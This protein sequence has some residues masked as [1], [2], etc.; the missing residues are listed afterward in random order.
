MLSLIDTKPMFPGWGLVYQSGV[1]ASESYKGNGLTVSMSGNE[2]WRD[3]C[4]W[5]NMRDDDV[6]VLTTPMLFAMTSAALGFLRRGFNVLIHCNEGKYRSTYLDVAVHIGAGMP[7]DDAFALVQARHP[8]ADLRNG[9]KAQLQEME[10][11]LLVKGN[12]P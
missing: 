12:K 1:I 5:I 7:F 9:T 11:Q 4:L 2:N 3:P 10:H 6:Y 8:I